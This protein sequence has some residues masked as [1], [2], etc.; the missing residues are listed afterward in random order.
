MNRTVAQIAGHYIQGPQIPEGVLNRLE[1]GIRA[2]DPCLS[3]STHAVGSMPLHVQ[4][5]AADGTIQ[6]EVWRDRSAARRSN[7][8]MPDSR[9]AS[10]FVIG[11]GNTLRRDDALGCLI[12]D[13]V[14]RWQRAG[15]RSVS[16]AQL[17][18]ELAPEL[19]AAETVF[20]V[21]ARMLPVNRAEHPGRA[22][23][24]ARQD[25]ASMVHALTPRFLLGLCR[26]AFGQCPTAW[27]VS[28]PG[29][30]F[31]FGEGLSAMAERGM[32]HALGMIETLI[33]RA[34]P[35]NLIPHL[36]SGSG[37]PHAPQAS[38]DSDHERAH[39]PG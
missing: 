3:C 2:F 9:A 11:F 15:V 8:P 24:A 18:P 36:C 22:A 33:A 23:G 1:A 37:S 16:L 14:E 28:V 26:A 34:V 13:E 6:H 31:S 21:D 7:L 25:W 20:F 39:H 27:L 38:Q 12:A 30:D 32:G 5:V 17:T 35:P 10:I 4:L 19:A 29:S